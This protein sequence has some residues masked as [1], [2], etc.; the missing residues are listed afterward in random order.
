MRDKEGEE[1]LS[2]PKRKTVHLLKAPAIPRPPSNARRFIMVPPTECG[3]VE[4]PSSIE[5]PEDFQA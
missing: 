1:D 2:R 5:K 3:F 4:V